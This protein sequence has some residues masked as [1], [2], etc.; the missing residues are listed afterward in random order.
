MQAPGDSVVLRQVLEALEAQ[1]LVSLVHDDVN[2][3]VLPI[4]TTIFAPSM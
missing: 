3:N 1:V 4:Y 2:L